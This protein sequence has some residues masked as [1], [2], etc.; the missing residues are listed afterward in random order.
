MHFMRYIYQLAEKLGEGRVF[1]VASVKRNR[2]G[3]NKVGVGTRRL[4]FVSSTCD[5]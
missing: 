1:M 5:V 4:I 2:T 3:V